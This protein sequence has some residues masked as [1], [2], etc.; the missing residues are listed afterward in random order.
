MEV[1]RTLVDEV[2]PRRLPVRQETGLEHVLAY[3]ADDDFLLVV[4]IEG[5][6][7]R[8]GC[9]PSIDVHKGHYNHEG[10]HGIT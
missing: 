8:T 2:G 6:N 5:C 3:A 10:Y 4:A 1:V 7:D 9:Y